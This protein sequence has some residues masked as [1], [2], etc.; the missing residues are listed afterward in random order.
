MSVTLTYFVHGTTIDNEQKLATGWLPGELSEIG[1]DQARALANQIGNKVFDVM[2]CS[3]LK[4]AIDSADIGFAGRCPIVQDPRLRECNYGDFDGMDKSFK[5]DM[6]KYI[7]VPYP[8]GE[9]YQDVEKR[10]AQ[11]L[12]DLKQQYE[13]REVAIMAHEAPQLALEVLLNNKTWEEVIAENWRTT[14]AWQ[15]GWIYTLK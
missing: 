5:R 7:S 3:D 13:G 6:T 8:N 9:S 4:R 15:P 1:R 14:G 10:L 12:A 2:I 11:F